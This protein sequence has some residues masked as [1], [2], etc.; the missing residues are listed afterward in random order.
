[1]AALA[2]LTSATYA[3]D[4]TNDEYIKTFGMMMFERKDRKSVV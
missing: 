1:M 4:N 3:A 2:A